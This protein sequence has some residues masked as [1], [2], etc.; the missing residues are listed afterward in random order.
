MSEEELPDQQA[1]QP[2]SDAAASWFPSIPAPVKRV[3]DQF[4]LTVYAPNELPSRSPRESSIHKLYIFTTDRAASNGSPSFNPQCLKWQ[5]RG[6]P[7]AI[8]A[9]PLVADPV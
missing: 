6:A 3:F 4:P 9:Q 7:I 8:Y 5:V 2:A 1:R